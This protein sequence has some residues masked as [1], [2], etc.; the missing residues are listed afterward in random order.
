MKKLIIINDLMEARVLK[1]YL[2]SNGIDVIFK[3][4]NAMGLFPQFNEIEGIELWVEDEQ[5]E[6]AKEIINYFQ[7]N[8]TKNQEN[9]PY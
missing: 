6:N 1:S 9:N 3:E 4:G 7:E 5:Y 2:E 8:N